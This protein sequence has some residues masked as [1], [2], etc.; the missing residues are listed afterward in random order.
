MYLND[1]QF[2]DVA[3]KH[4]SDMTSSF[5]SKTEKFASEIQSD[6]K[7]RSKPILKQSTDVGS[8]TDG[9]DD[10]STYRAESRVAQ[11]GNTSKF[12]HLFCYY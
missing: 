2:A 11:Y 6:L 9:G 1:L 12:L 4:I 8:A 5:K 3:T 7:K 10:P